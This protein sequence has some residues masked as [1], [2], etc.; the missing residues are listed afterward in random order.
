MVENEGAAKTGV[1]FMG[2]R[3]TGDLGLARAGKSS[4]RGVGHGRVGWVDEGMVIVEERGATED[5]GCV[6]GGRGGVG[7]RGGEKASV[8]VELDLG[9]IL[10]PY[11]LQGC[12]F[13]VSACVWCLRLGQSAPFCASCCTHN[14]STLM[15]FM[16]L[17]FI[18]MLYP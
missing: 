6:G 11:E 12:V 14:L 1:E 4:S 17:Q 15:N 7:R 5:S 2:E 3:A 18:D 10:H 9:I 13:P 16:A 8:E